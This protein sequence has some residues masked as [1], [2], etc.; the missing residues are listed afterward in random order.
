RN[1]PK[2]SDLAACRSSA[3][4]SST[5]DCGSRGFIVRLGQ[6]QTST[7]PWLLAKY[8]WYVFQVHP[9]RAYGE[10]MQ[11]SLPCTVASEGL[12]ARISSVSLLILDSSSSP[13]NATSST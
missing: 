13:K 11:M 8:F 6:F 2:Y 12:I 9:L 3:M 1:S 4:A 10:E 5:M 7:F